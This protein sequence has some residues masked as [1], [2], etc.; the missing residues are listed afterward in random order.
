MPVAIAP[1]TELLHDPGQQPGRRVVERSTEGLGLGPLLVGVARL[2]FHEAPGRRQVGLLLVT[3]R[4]RGVRRS[5]EGHVEMD[6]HAVSGVQPADPGRHLCAPVT[7]LRDVLRVA[8][9][10]H[11]RDERLGD[12]EFVPARRARGFREPVARQRRCDHMEAVFR[13][14]A[15]GFRVGEPWDD[16]EEL[17][18]GARPSVREEQWHGIGMSRPGMDEVDR[19]PV[20][21]GLEL[22]ERVQPIFLDPPVVAVEPVVDQLA[23]VVGRDAVLPPGAVDLIREAGP[24][25]A[26]VQVLENR[27]VNL[28]VERINRLAHV[29]LSASRR[30][31]WWQRRGQARP[32]TSTP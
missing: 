14:P 29:V 22:A 27:F 2:L 25:Q 13:V 20:N 15:E 16:V 30:S 19:L 21:P 6:G 24:L 17:D 10:A 8:E 5:T 3:E 4:N 26:M 32:I 11:Q 9:S 1:G 18:D 7:A 12:A 23:Q 28:N 31:R